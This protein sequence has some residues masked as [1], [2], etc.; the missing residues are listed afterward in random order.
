MLK[1]SLSAQIIEIADELPDFCSS[2]LL[3]SGAQLSAQTR[4][5]Y[6]YELIWFF[7]Y[8]INYNPH[9]SEMSKKDIQ[10]SDL[11]QISTTD[12]NRY[13]SILLEKLDP[14]TVARKRSAI[15]SFF[16]YISSGTGAL[17]KFNPVLGS[18]HVKIPE[19]DT[20]I[21]LTIEEQRTLI[22]C[23]KKGIGLSKRQLQYHDKYKKR[24]SALVLLILDTGIR[25]SELHGLDIA[26]IDLE[27]CSAIVYRKR[28]KIQTVY[29][30]DETKELL[31]DYLLE[32]R[33]HSPTLT[34][35]EPLFSTLQG[36][37]LAVRSIEAMIKKYA[38]ASLGNKASLISV[39]KLRSSFAMAY[40]STTNRDILAL[41]KAL[42][43]SSITAT[44]VYAKASNDTLKGNRHLLENL[45]KN[46]KS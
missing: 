18:V 9:F 40:Y 36:E 7:D 17:I 39:H 6:G 13:T 33:I 8:L 32:R 26:D 34:A 10:V 12:I 41:Q 38:E 44:N 27:D 30:S 4:R 43:H 31:E 28:N 42:G 1:K 45:R 2:F 5:A 25:V 35:D 3:E 15:S 23:I 21:Y 24:D 11:N 37:R 19:K 16:N 29:F 20:V 46:I 14:Q 22:D